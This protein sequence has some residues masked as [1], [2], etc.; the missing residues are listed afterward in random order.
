M[1]LS[2]STYVSIQIGDLEELEQR[3]TREWWRV[4]DVN[5]RLGLDLTDESDPLSV[6]VR[7]LQQLLGRLAREES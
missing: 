4:M 6:I 3:P 5:A 1:T 2:W 7:D